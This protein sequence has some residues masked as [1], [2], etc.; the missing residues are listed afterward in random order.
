ME[1]LFDLDS[2]S[3]ED[4]KILKKEINDKLETI[5]QDNFL[6]AIKKEVA[7]KGYACRPGCRDDIPGLHK[8]EL[9]YYFNIY[10][11][12]YNREDDI[13]V[14]DRDCDQEE[15]VQQLNFDYQPQDDDASDI[16]DDW[17]RDAHDSPFRAKVKMMIPVYYQYLDKPPARFKAIFE[18]GNVED[19]ILKNSIIYI[20]DEEICSLGDHD[21]FIIVPCWNLSP[22]YEVYFRLHKSNARLYLFNSWRAGLLYTPNDINTLST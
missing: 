11:W 12:D 20:N 14:S 8:L 16:I 5:R 9:P 19:A 10:T 6:Q 1:T 21:Y 13:H 2:F 17:D 15:W 18:D 22:V 3:E 4:L 7:E